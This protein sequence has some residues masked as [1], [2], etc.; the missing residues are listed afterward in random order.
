MWPKKH[1]SPVR[2]AED[3]N[4]ARSMRSEATANLQELRR[5]DTYISGMVTR[6]IDR[7]V[8]N[9]FGDQIDISYQRKNA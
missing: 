6:L 7:R 9:G 4:E 5:N 1:K 2:A 3:V 8:E